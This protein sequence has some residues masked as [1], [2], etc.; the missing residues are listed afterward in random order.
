[1]GF[2]LQNFPGAGTTAGSE[3][4]FS[5]HRDAGTLQPWWDRLSTGCRTWSQHHPVPPAI[6]SSPPPRPGIG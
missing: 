1:M 6:A 5:A 3:A 4:P 2:S